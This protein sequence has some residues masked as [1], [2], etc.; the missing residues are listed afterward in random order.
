MG[1]RG[2]I[3]WYKSTLLKHKPWKAALWTCAASWNSHQQLQEE[4]TPG[5]NHFIRLEDFSFYYTQLRLLLTIMKTLQRADFSAPLFSQEHSWCPLCNF[6]SSWDIISSL[7]IIQII[8]SLPNYYI[9]LYGV[10]RLLT[11]S[12]R[13]EVVWGQSSWRFCS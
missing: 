6:I 10:P 8:S 12:Q 7:P 4:F 9:L 13:A 1:H 3:N 11:V 5:L 2:I